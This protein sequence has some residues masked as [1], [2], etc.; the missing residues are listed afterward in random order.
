MIKRADTCELNPHDL[1]L[2]VIDAVVSLG[3]L[4]LKI[5]NFS[6]EIMEDVFCRIMPIFFKLLLRLRNV[7]YNQIF[8]INRLQEVFCLGSN[9][10]YAGMPFTACNAMY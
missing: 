10:N 3:K 9:I 5:G 6:F 4:L 2:Q 7:M 8:L 1:I